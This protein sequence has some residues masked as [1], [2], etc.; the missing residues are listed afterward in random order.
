VLR[1]VLVACLTAAVV[2][3]GGATAPADTAEKI[4]DRVVADTVDGKQASFLVVLRGQA[5]VLGD[6]AASTNRTEQG[7]LAVAALRRAAS[8]Q[9][10]VRSALR[11][12]GVPFRPFWIVN[13]VAAKGDRHVVAALARR[14]DVAAIE[15]DRA[16]A[17]VTAEAAHSA[18][19]A[20]RGVEW[21][22]QRVGAAAL[23][24]LGF[25]GQGLVY[26]NA[27]T[28]VKWDAPALKRQYRGWDGTAA[29]HAYSWWDAVHSDLD[30]DGGNP[31]GFSVRE[32]CD[33][34]AAD[35]SHGTH[36]MGTAVGDDGAGNQIGV[37]P[38][39]RW[40]ACR[41][42]D[43]GVGRPSTYIECLQ[44]FLAPTD[45]DG[46]NPDPARR[47][48]VVGNSYACP[49]DEGCS[50][51]SLQAAVDNLRAAGV[52]MTVAAGN[53]GEFGCASVLFPPAIYDSVV[54]VGATDMSD[55]IA[56]FSSRGPVQVDAS[57]RLKPD[58]A[59][60]G[61]SIRSSTASGYGVLSGTSMAA[62]HVGGAALLLWSALPEL[63]GNVDATEQLLKE[64]ALA[65]TTTNGCGGDTATATP[66]NTYGHGRIDIAAAYG[67]TTA[68]AS[69]TTAD[70]TVTEGDTGRRPARFTVTVSRASA[71]AITV[72]YAAKP[73][74]AAAGS[75]FV[76]VSG[77]L[78]LSPGQRSKTIAVPVLGDRRVEPDETFQLTLSGPQNARFGR[79]TAV[80]RIRND[81]VDRTKPVLAR[82][83]VTPS[84]VVAGRSGRLGYTVS[85]AARIACTIERRGAA[86]WLPVG[87]LSI[88]G[89][90]GARVAFLPSA[91]FRAGRYRVS[92]V[93]T[94]LSRNVGRPAVAEFVVV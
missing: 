36:T 94:D 22:V 41:N 45:L 60:P 35:G 85:E 19:A 70:A 79:A 28:G 88:N 23:W 86:T 76:P 67:S 52:F 81:D 32:P 54:S 44:F 40:I 93:A 84:P 69:L 12:L 75:D 46:L 63:R 53:E 55:Q 56:F 80:G 8:A 37:A 26:A 33:D 7:E 65:R 62:P 91:G 3:T 50:V 48:N 64:T 10:G 42:M 2:L 57:G 39:A 59:A 34:S 66:N 92:C 43:Q 30:G 6:A 38:G 51:G 71:Q 78:T 61:V 11:E 89:R 24:A 87:R 47:P 15:P 27:D 72:R 4:D 5:D 16:F 9:T 1:V 74:T 21:N 31:C 77:K 83:A 17:G 18:S 58:L 90:A 25:T 68:P 13:A 49:P 29:N 14:D 73:R 82:L 20:P